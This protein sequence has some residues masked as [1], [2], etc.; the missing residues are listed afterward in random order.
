MLA[1]GV[2]ELCE[3][4]FMLFHELGYMSGMNGTEPTSCPYD[5]R[6]SG[7]ILS[8]G[9]AILMLETESHAISRSAKILARIKGYGNAFDPANGYLYGTGIGL[10][11]AINSALVDS[12]I[13]SN[14]IDYICGGANSS[15][16]LDMIET[17]VIQ[18]IF[19]NSTPV[20]SIKSM[21]GETFSAAGAMAL[22]AAIGGM[23]KKFIPPTINY[24]EK[25]AESGLNIVA[26]EAR[27]KDINNVLV[28][29]S[30]PLG[31]N[32]ALIIDRI[33]NE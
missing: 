27:K 28:L 15:K 9:S 31:N 13:E 3:E 32:T 11:N 26:N 30:D 29:S 6:R 12:S 17:R 14:E 33:N 22:S 4:T 20:S 5:K 8:E 24:L 23:N 7:F 18:D 21:T 10:R 1:G 16:E 19:G 2:E 25:D